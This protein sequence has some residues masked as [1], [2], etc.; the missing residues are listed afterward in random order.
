MLVSNRNRIDD[1]V[2][3]G[4]VP[5]KKVGMMVGRFYESEEPSSSREE[6]R[7]VSL[8]CF[9]IS[10]KLK[11]GKDNFLGKRVAFSNLNRIAQAVQTRDNS[12]ELG[13]GFIG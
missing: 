9:D 6:N 5:T 7:R 3:V 4:K 10:I 1:A 11:S 8:G 13:D 12:F 2:N